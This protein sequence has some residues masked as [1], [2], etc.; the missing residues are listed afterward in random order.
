MQQ[1]PVDKTL[2]RL[3]LNGQC[4]QEQLAII[5][6]YLYDPAYQ[7]S[8]RELMLMD[9]QQVAG[10]T[11]M[12]EEP[13]V[14]DYQQFLAL[15]EPAAAIPVKETKGKLMPLRR[16]WQVAAAVF[17]GT[18]GWIGWQWQQNEKHQ[19]LV[20]R[21][22]E[23]VQFH[24]GAGKRTM[25]VLPDSSQVYLNA[26]SSLQYNK[27]FGITNRN[28][29]LEGEAYFIVKHGWKQPF[30][31]RSGSISTVDIGTAFNI[32][33]RGTDPIVKVAVAEG[34]VNVLDHNQPQGGLLSLLTK[35]HQLDFDARTRHAIVHALPD[36]EPVAGWRQGIL[37]FHKQSLKEVAAELERYYDIHIR[38]AQPRT[39]DILITTTI[40]NATAAEALN[41][42]SITTG[43]VVEKTE[44]EVLI[45]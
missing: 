44:K 8:L 36:T 9:W 24:N 13:P 32:R 33:Y 25:I 1:Q 11:F 42:I 35:Q 2:L 20:K 27:N 43:V 15:V 19:Q 6:Q 7:E 45:K 5:Q 38:F 37:A 18:I 16:W 21:E 40:H 29:L 22:H 39:A 26:V 31:V 28:L 3:Y 10:E 34:A 41:V 12:P 17:I 23:W 14:D 30:S 4:T